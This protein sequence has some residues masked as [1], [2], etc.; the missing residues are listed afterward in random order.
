MDSDSLDYYIDAEKTR[1]NQDVDRYVSDDNS[2]NESECSVQSFDEWAFQDGGYPIEGF[3]ETT[4]TNQ[5]T[6]VSE[7]TSTT[8][9]TKKG[10][11]WAM[12]GGIIF[13]IFAV[14]FG[15]WY[16]KFGGKQKIKDKKKQAGDWWSGSSSSGSS[17]SGSSGSVSA[18]P[19]PVR[20]P[21]PSVQY[22]QSKQGQHGQQGQKKKT[23]PG[24]G[25]GVDDAATDYVIATSL[26]RGI[27]P[28][29]HSSS[30]PIGFRT[31]NPAA[32]NPGGNSNFMS[33][34]SSSHSSSLG[35]GTGTGGIDDWSMCTIM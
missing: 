23:S 11:N 12:I 18:S 1:W 7:T 6:M 15:V 21:N 31:T 25:Y 16:F 24:S 22:N 3:A 4:T 32:T 13:L 10:P 28:A 26:T 27:N 19:A 5:E 20:P 30:G 9:T 29:G 8:T 2:D 14:G 34:S 17:S 33:H 35:A